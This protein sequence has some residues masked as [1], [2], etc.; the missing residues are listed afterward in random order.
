MTFL[1]KCLSSR[2]GREFE[3]IQVRS[4]DIP[5]CERCGSKLLEKLFAP[6]VSHILKGDNWAKDSYGLKKSKK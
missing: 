4:D 1:Y 3:Y 2:C 5:K 6:K